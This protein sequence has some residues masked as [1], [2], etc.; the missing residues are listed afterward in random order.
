L[1]P[2]NLNINFGWLNRKFGKQFTLKTVLL[3]SKLLRTINYGKAE[4][5]RN[6]NTNAF[7]KSLLGETLADLRQYCENFPLV[8]NRQVQLCRLFVV[9]ILKLIPSSNDSAS[10][11][12]AHKFNERIPSPPL[13]P[14][15]V[16]IAALKANQVS[17]VTSRMTCAATNDALRLK[18]LLVSNKRVYDPANNRT[19]NTANS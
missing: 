18:R 9:L 17:V 11:V 15:A 13:C 3:K 16:A 7:D 12:C 8:V 19:G 10:Y 1:R 5:L 2:I 14:S 4:N 6:R